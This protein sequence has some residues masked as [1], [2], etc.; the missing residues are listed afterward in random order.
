MVVHGLAI[1]G[2]IWQRRPCTPSVIII[3]LGRCTE[4]GLL[5]TVVHV[6][7]R[8]HDMQCER[9]DFRLVRRSETPETSH[10]HVYGCSHP[11]ART[12]FCP[13]PLMLDLR[14]NLIYSLS[15][16]DPGASTGASRWKVAPSVHAYRPAI[17]TLSSRQNMKG[18]VFTT[19]LGKS[20]ET[21]RMV[22]QDTTA[23]T[24]LPSFARRSSSL[25]PD[26]LGHPDGP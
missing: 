2:N 1:T 7:L 19:A 11:N 15:L 8:G 17:R 3:A 16:P 6:D 22:V 13:T 9:W 4:L 24:Y 23:T 12:R 18:L 25:R 5:A 26:A 21:V 14:L 10:T 20:Q